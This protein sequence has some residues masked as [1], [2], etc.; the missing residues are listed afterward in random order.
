MTEKITLILILHNR[1]KNIDRLLEYYD[2]YDFPIVIADSSKEKHVFTSMKPN[3]QHIY[4][5]D[6]FFTDKLEVVLPQITTPYLLM[7]A[8]DDFIIPKSII[9]CVSFLETHPDYAIAQ[10]LAIRY[11]KDSVVNSNI[12]FGPIYKIYQSVEDTE[13]LKRLQHF[14][15]PYRS[16]FY[17]VF[18]TSAIQQ[19]FKGTKSVVKKLFL[20]EYITAFLPILFGKYKELPILYHVREHAHDSDDKTA[21]DIDTLTNE[22]Q[23]SEEVNEFENLVAKKM[24]VIVH[25]STTEAKQIVNTTLNDFSD[26]LRK[27]RNHIPFKKRIGNVI[28]HL[29]F[30]GKWMIKKNRDAENKNRLS[31]YY[32]LQ[33]DPEEIK[34]ITD[35]LYKYSKG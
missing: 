33:S 5:P 21:I 31:G 13:P 14:F 1:H 12:Q 24:S 23:Y 9:E 16:V 22:E 17:A 27:L 29:P 8:D 19:S 32:D 7:C 4:T 25:I 3:W 18:R 30:L 34:A 11:D 35:L 6:V 10:G 2:D 26:R 28:V 20:N 15:H